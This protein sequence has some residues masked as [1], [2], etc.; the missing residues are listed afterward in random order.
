MNHTLYAPFN[1][2]QVQSMNGFQVRSGMHPMTC[3]EDDCRSATRAAPMTATTLGWMCRDC[4]YRQDW[5]FTF[6]ADWSWVQHADS[7]AMLFGNHV[8]KMNDNKHP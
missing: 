5:T 3:R 2:Q 1:G 6:T 7:V 4:D 8:T